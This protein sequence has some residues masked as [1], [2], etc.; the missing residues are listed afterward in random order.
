[1][2]RTT[3]KGLLAHKLRVLLTAI[4]VILGVA[5]VAGTLVLSDTI[6]KTFDTAIDDNASASDIDVMVSLDS[7]LDETSNP[8]F[9]ATVL[10]Q[11][12]AVDG[13]ASATGA[14]GGYAQLVDADG[15]VVEGGFGGSTVSNW[16]PTST[17]VTIVEG[18]APAG[19][20]QFVLDEDTAHDNGFAVGDHAQII[21][22]TGSSEYELV[23]IAH[24]EVDMLGAVSMVFDTPTTQRI[25][26]RE[27]LFDSVGVRAADG[28]DD[29][30]VADR[31]AAAVGA[32]YEVQ[33]RAEMTAEAHS[34][35]RESMAFIDIFLLVF[36]FI[37]LF[38]G[39]FIIYNTFSIIVTQRTREMAL[40]RAIG[41]SGRQVLGSVI[42]EA[43]IVGAVASAVGLGVGV[44]VAGALKALLAFVGLDIP[45]GAPV[46][47]SST[48]IVSMAVGTLVTL[49][50]AIGPA[51][52]AAKVAP[53]AALRDAGPA[54]KVGSVRRSVVGGLTLAAGVAAV[55][56][57]LGGGALPLVGLGTL[58]TFV[59]MAAVA[60]TIAR[61]VTR[62]IG[63]PLA[64]TRGIT[65]ELAREN[66][67]RSPKRTAS[68]AS[69]LMIGVAL[70]V[71]TVIL[72]ASVTNYIRGTVE[73]GAKA[74]VYLS[75]AGLTS[76]GF[77]PAIAVAVD[78][79]PEVG[80]A[81]GTYNGP[82]EVEGAS[83]WI[84]AADPALW[85]DT[86]P[87]QGYDIGVTSGAITDLVDGGIALQTDAAED[88]DVVVGDTVE[89][90]YPSGI[91]QERVDAIFED[92]GYFGRYLV[93]IDTYEANYADLLQFSAFI[94]AADGISADQAIA[95]VQ[96]LVDSSFPGT[97]VQD[98]DEFIQSYVDGTKMLIGLIGALLSLAILIALLGV[99][100]TLALSIFERTRELGL[101]RAIGMTRSQLRAM[102][103]HEAAIIATFGAALG[104]S[105]GAFFGT[106]LVKALAG[107]GM[108]EVVVP[109]VQVAVLV[110]LTSLLGVAAA[111]LPARK[112]ARIDVLQ[113]LAAD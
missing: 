13:V 106:A 105:V 48:V 111:I 7:G 97:E 58:V 77:S 16:D 38:V 44:G 14:V 46:V 5:F 63:A 25:V 10:A 53:I 56:A 54:A 20:G 113:A 34:D 30:V 6:T 49:I 76:T 40:L 93:G 86:N 64:K 36:A 50:S 70:V 37:S 27:G 92:N 15:T 85:D 82:S 65:G 109:P 42:L 8:P 23:G 28:V 108:T 89:V 88:L 3:V 104:L 12:A 98:R 67:S 41:A 17:I 35:I 43:V 87:D 81:Y 18:H 4:S 96:Q 62:L 2:F 39:A 55:V 24:S 33:T 75:D 1:M 26:D 100:N 110:G 107:E 80:E 61:P 78:G 71:V 19:D 91:H 69:A 102:V 83:Q 103:R 21:T 57:G 99:A 74:D 47:A 72:G 90:E 60:P 101:L 68:T 32:D 94:T 29:A 31:V 95:A 22:V 84:S 51:R 112:A 11:V 52:K 45:T 66:A 59:G 79:L 73:D 9:P